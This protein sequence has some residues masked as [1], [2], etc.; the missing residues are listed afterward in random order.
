MATIY[1][2][3]GNDPFSTMTGGSGTDWIFGLGGDDSIDGLGGNDYLFGGN[4]DD[5]L[6]GYTGNDYLYGDSGNDDLWGEDGN[7]T[8]IGGDG[9]DTLYGGSGNDYLDAGGGFNTIETG[10]GSDQIVLSAS[11]YNHIT[12]FQ[13]GVDHILLDDME[14]NS[15]GFSA[16]PNG[17]TWILNDGGFAIA[18]LVNVAESQLT[19]ADFTTI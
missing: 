16:H 10:S 7:D 3:N 11:S 17:G 4:G 13:D 2:T 14:F 8:L 5:I 9:W 18:F 15:L 1:G 6:W 12:D 19:A